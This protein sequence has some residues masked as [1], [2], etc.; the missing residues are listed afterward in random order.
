M[1]TLGADM[2]R[3]DPG[4]V[5]IEFGHRS[6]LT[7]QHGFLHAGVIT[8]VVDSA[9]GYSALSLMPPGAE[10][11]AVEF[12]VN[13]LSPAKGAHF[14]ARGRVVRPGRTLTVCRGE[15]VDVSGEEER[16]IAA[17]LST[18]IAVYDRGDERS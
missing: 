3:V 5:E 2:V 11:L 16:P 17:M 10:V 13:L 14:V 9:C 15:V 1:A 18:M 4:V 7:Q 12:K 6:D 8:S